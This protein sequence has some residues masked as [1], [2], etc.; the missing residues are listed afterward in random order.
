MQAARPGE[1]KYVRE[2]GVIALATFGA[3]FPADK[4][5]V[6]A[7]LE[8]YLHESN[9]RLRGAAAEALG[10]LG[11]PA[12]RGALMA[13]ASRETFLRTAQTMRKIAGD[14]GRHTPLEERVKQLEIQLEKLQREEHKAQ[15]K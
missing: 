11:E 7:E 13:A 3:Q 5:K 9:L 8:G 4:D 12:A 10:V 2:I 1:H 14:L 15:A 6:R